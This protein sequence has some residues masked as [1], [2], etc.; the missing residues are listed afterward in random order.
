MQVEGVGLARRV[1]GHGERDLDGRVGGD[2]V[3]AAVGEELGRGERAAEDLE[4][5]GDG[6]GREGVAVDVEVG[7]VEAEVEV[8]RVVDA[9][10]IGRAGRCEIL[11]RDEVGLVQRQH[12]RALVRGRLNLRRAVVPQ[13]SRVN[14]AVEAGRALIGNRAN[15]VV[16][17]VLVG[18]K[19]ER[20]PLTSEDINLVNED[21]LVVDAVDLDCPAA[22]LHQA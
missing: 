16:V 13:N 22:D 6:G 21:G 2:D 3:D 10:D 15:P 1:G 18:R 11:E 9:A 5:H 12:T 17:D 14:A 8:E 19:D 7:A 4:Q 20:V